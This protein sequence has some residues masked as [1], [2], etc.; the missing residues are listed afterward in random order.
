MLCLVHRLYSQLTLIRFTA[1]KLPGELEN[2]L[3]APFA[4]TLQNDVQ[5]KLR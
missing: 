3:Y 2:R 5:G 1:P 4:G